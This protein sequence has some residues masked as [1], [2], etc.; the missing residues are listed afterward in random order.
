[1]NALI[2]IFKFSPIIVL[3]ALVMSGFDMLMAVP[4]AF[5]YAV[6]VC[7]ITVKKKAEDIIEGAFVNVKNAMSVF[8]IFML[9]YGVAQI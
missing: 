6:I 1:M 8:F 5:L 2:T 9:A 4:L 3:C 7:K